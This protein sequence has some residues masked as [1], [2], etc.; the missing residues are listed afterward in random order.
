M[1]GCKSDGEFVRTLEEGIR[2]R[3]AM[4]TLITD[5]AQAEI[6]KKVKDILRMY[7]IKDL[8]NEAHFQHQN[9]CG[10]SVT[11]IRSFISTNPT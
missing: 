8:Q 1:H 6:Q 4:D 11:A 5:N 3:G 9:P 2:Q 7:L 10:I